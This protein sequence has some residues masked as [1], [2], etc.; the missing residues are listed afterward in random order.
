MIVATTAGNMAYKGTRREPARTF[1]LCHTC[2][3]YPARGAQVTADT[4]KNGRM[5]VLVTTCLPCTG[6]TN[7]QERL[8][9]AMKDK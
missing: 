9:A 8:E 3:T 6:T 5:T 1:T 2:R 4:W 7:P